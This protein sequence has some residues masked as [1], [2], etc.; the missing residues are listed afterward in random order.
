MTFTFDKHDFG[1]LNFS[2]KIENFSMMKFFFWI[3]TGGLHILAEDKSDIISRW[4]ADLQVEYKVLTNIDR[5][6]RGF[7]YQGKLPLAPSAAVRHV[8]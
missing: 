8:F 4:A 1:K 5:A 6:D 2:K 3:F 7:K